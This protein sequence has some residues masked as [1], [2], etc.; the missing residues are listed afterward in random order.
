MRRQA[1]PDPRGAPPHLDSAPDLDRPP[2]QG[3]SRPPPRPVPNP[4]PHP[5]V[6]RAYLGRSCSASRGTSSAQAAG[7]LPGPRAPPPGPSEGRS[8]PRGCRAKGVLR[9]TQAGVRRPRDA[10][11]R[12]KE[13][14]CVIGW[15][16]EGNAKP[17]RK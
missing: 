5:R 13:R 2:P 4:G 10:K 11:G 7:F 15:K 3:G 6:R 8:R 17:D 12:K 16:G 14:K 9:A 1:T